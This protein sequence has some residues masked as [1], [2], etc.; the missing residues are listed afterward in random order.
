MKMPFILKLIPVTFVAAGLFLGCG[1]AHDHD[2]DHDHDGD[3]KPD[4]GP[5]EHGA[6]AKGDDYPLKTC[7]VS[8]EDLESMGGAFVHKHEGVT[9]KFCCEGCVEDF[10]KDPKKFLAKLE[11]AKKGELPKPTTETPDEGEK[12]KEPGESSEETE[13]GE[14]PA[15]T[16]QESSE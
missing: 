1:E 7:L 16:P 8:D 14:K 15:P 3:G 10:Q 13:G 4:H 11:A 12:P 5:G 6:S 2:H 9:V